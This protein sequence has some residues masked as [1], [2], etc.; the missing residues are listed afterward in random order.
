MITKLP[1]LV[2]QAVADDIS[3]MTEIKSFSA[4]PMEE[5]VTPWLMESVVKWLE[6]C[7]ISSSTLLVSGPLRSM[8]G[9]SSFDLL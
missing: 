6:V 5:F 2:D 4:S 9:P 1:S 3:L 7:S 8:A